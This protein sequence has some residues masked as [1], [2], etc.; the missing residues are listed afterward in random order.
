M[1]IMPLLSIPLIFLGARF[2]TTAT[3]LPTISSG[4]KCMAIPETIVLISNPRSTSSFEQLICL[5]HLFCLQNNSCPQI[6]LPKIIINYFWLDDRAFSFR[7]PAN[8]LLWRGV[9]ACWG[10]HRIVSCGSDGVVFTKPSLNFFTCLS[11]FFI[12]NLPKQQLRRPQAILPRLTTL[13]FPAFSQ[14]SILSTTFSMALDL[15]SSKW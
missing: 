10:F 2:A 5:F 11:I 15:F 3:F 14:S 12:L 4:V 6:Q 13:I 1:R 9:A 7:L 8:P